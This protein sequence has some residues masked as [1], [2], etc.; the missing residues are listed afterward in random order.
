MVVRLVLDAGVQLRIPYY[1]ICNK[2][3]MILALYNLVDV[4]AFLLQAQV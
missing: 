4:L 2:Q 3:L 1:I